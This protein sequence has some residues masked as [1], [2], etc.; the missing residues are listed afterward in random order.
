MICGR[1]FDDERNLK[2]EELR[3][4]PD[5]FI[6]APKTFVTLPLVPPRIHHEAS[7]RGGACA[8]IQE[9]DAKFWIGGLQETDTSSEALETA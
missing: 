4:V 6:P 8:R 2:I 7:W 5:S 9:D 3:S 1:M